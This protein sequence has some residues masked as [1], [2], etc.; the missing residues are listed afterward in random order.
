M[1]LQ[2]INEPGTSPELTTHNDI[3]FIHADQQLFRNAY[4]IPQN[5]SYHNSGCLFI[6]QTFTV[7]TLNLFPDAWLLHIY[8]KHA[9]RLLRIPYFFKVLNHILKI[10]SDRG[11]L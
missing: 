5:H 9:K 1:F 3:E 10:E 11:P 4:I 2:S 7:V 6:V 8:T